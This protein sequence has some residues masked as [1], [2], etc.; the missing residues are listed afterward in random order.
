M[1]FAYDDLNGTKLPQALTNA[2]ELYQLDRETL[3]RKRHIITHLYGFDEAS[4]E[5]RTTP[6][7]EGFICASS[8]GELGRLL[9]KS[10]KPG[11]DL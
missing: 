9:S 6:A 8:P 1:L 5:A 10:S 2:D 11:V 4:W 3:Q 7:V